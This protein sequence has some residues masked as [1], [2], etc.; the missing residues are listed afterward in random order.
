ML[1][2]TGLP[3][4]ATLGTAGL[5][6]VV[7]PDTVQEIIIAADSDPAGQKAALAAAERLTR[8]GHKVRIAT[9]PQHHKDFNA[10]KQKDLVV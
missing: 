9:P 1:Q 3:T 5:K 6:G 7:L 8:E 4:W 2:A 10:L